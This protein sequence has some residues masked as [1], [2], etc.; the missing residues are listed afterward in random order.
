MSEKI[1]KI[2]CKDPHEAQKIAKQ[3]SKQLIDNPDFMNHKIFI[4]H[5]DVEGV[6]YLLV[7]DKTEHFDITI[8]L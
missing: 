4:N 3:I 2:T 6:C 1:V 5:T 7:N 8:T